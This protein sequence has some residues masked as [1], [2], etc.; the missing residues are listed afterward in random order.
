MKILKKLLFITFAG[1]LVVSCTKQEPSPATTTTQ[2]APS[3]SI[4]VVNPTFENQKGQS[5][6]WQD[7]HGKTRVMAMIFSH[8]PAA[9]PIITEQIKSAEHLLPT[10]ASGNVGFTLVSF[11]SKRDTA[12]RLQEFYQEHGLDS[13]W[14]LLH[15][16]PEDV[17]TIA[18]LLNVQYKEW[19]GGDFTHSDVIFVIDT[20]GN[21][22]LRQEGI[23]PQNPG[24][25]AQ[26]VTSLLR[27]KPN[28]H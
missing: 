9:C 6:S 21:I 11:D 8:C 7:L 16:A 20:A 10:S 22:V 13:N 27:T 12:G 5:V 4:Y 14:T 1:A 28:I 23:A 3:G 19:P 15:G 17:R 2:A 24:A 25:I 26:S 18:G